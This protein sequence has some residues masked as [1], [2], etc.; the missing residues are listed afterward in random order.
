MLIAKS[1][2][3][4]YNLARVKPTH[5]YQIVVDKNFCEIKEF[6]YAI[7]RLSFILVKKEED[8]FK[9]ERITHDLIVKRGVIIGKIENNLIESIGTNREHLNVAF[10]LSDIFE[11]DIDFSTDLRKGD[12]F[13]IVVEE[14]YR[15]NIFEGFGD[16]LYSEFTNNGNVHEAFRVEINGKGEYFTS[17]GKSVRKALLRAPLRFRYIS[18]S[19]THRRKHPILRIYRPHLGVDYAAPKG[20]PVSAAG[21]GKVT[22]AAYKGQNGKLAV[23]KHMNGYKTYYGHLSGFAKGVKKGKFVK[24]GQIIGFVGSTGLSTGPHLDY[25]VKLNNKNINPLKMK[26]PRS[27]P[28]PSKYKKD[29]NSFIKEMR[30]LANVNANVIV[31]D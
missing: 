3:K 28:L 29:F 2:R 14:R 16:I 24:Q 11:W 7:D 8:G 23:I 1:S 17:K 19:Y 25:R 10:A 18:S 5:S 20:T 15:K 27:E 31:N 22:F 9:A 6:K 4:I 26:L 13:R 30:G 12:T 21:D